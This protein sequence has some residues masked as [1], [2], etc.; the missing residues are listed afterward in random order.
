MSKFT[1]V[2]KK[3][4]EFD[5]FIIENSKTGER[6]SLTKYGANLL[7]Y[8]VPIHNELFDIL[9][10]FNSPEEIIAARGARN[11][12]MAPFANRVKD[13]LYNFN[14]NAHQLKPIP[15]RSQV[16]HGFAAY[17]EFNIK[18]VV[19][20]SNCILI[21]FESQPISS[22]QYS[23]Y[24]FDIQIRVA[25]KLFD[26]KIEITV[27][28]I[29]N[30]KEPAPFWSGWHPYFK[31]NKKGIENLILTIPAEK[32]ILVDREFIPLEGE[33]AF[34]DIEKYPNKNFSLLVHEDKKRIGGRKLNDCYADFQRDLTGLIRANI[35]DD[36]NGLSIDVFQSEGYL[37]AFT[38]EGLIRDPRKSIALEPMQCMTNAYNREEFIKKITLRPKGVS[39][40]SFGVEWEVD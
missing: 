21:E 27:S 17:Q 12:I 26:K 1:L 5:C 31:T 28:G 9:D 22:S 39:T 34:G 24:P 11:Y 35:F 16:I 20:N 2:E 8:E 18:D 25:Y 33:A 36:T 40:F 10:G 14:Y 15:P 7:S 19:N 38:G 4:G 3:F 37:L 32:I 29:N 23:G 13:G 30:G 6:I